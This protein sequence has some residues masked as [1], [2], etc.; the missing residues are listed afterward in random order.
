MTICGIY[1]PP[2]CPIYI[3]ISIRIIIVFFI[4]L[5]DWINKST[6]DGFG[7]VLQNKWINARVVGIENFTDGEP[8]TLQLE[9]GSYNGAVYTGS[10]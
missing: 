10:Y 4:A 8:L 1:R 7:F 6:P 5:F 9:V 2:I 3:C